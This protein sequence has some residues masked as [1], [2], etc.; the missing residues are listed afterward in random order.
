MAVYVMKITKYGDQKKVTVPKTWLKEAR[1]DKREYLAI[2]K[3]NETQWII[4]GIELEKENG[5][6]GS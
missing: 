3:L 4:G 5:S 2:K 1:L 6:K